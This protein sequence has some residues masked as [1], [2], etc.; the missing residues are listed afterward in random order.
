[1]GTASATSSGLTVETGVQVLGSPNGQCVKLW[2]P[3]PA[4]RTWAVSRLDS[5]AFHWGLGDPR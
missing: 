1:V 2:V 3:I 4:G 5:R